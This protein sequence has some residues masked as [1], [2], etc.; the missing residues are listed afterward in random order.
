MHVFSSPFFEGEADS[1]LLVGWSVEKR[2][3]SKMTVVGERGRALAARIGRIS[4]CTEPGRQCMSV[5]PVFLCSQ[6][7]SECRAKKGNV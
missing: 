5:G 3:R 1:L 4:F 2:G 6:G 7:A